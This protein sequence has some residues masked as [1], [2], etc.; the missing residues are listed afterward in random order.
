MDG[1]TCA[2]IWSLTNVLINNCDLMLE[3]DEQSRDPKS[4]DKSFCEGKFYGNT[5]NIMNLA[6]ASQMDKCKSYVC[7]TRIV[8][9]L[10]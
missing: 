1:V 9:I 3:L 8:F 2:A 10:G 5:I 4:D 7:V 6:Q